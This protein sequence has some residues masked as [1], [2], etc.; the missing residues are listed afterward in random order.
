MSYAVRTDHVVA[1]PLA[2]VRR[3]TPSAQLSRVVPEACGVVWA[4]LKAAGARGAGRHV[5][6][7]RGR[8]DG[9]IDEE[10]GAEV[11]AAFAGHGEVVRSA[12]P[13]GEVAAVTHFGPY[14]RLG[15]AHRA[16]RDW[17]A[18]H[19]RTPAGPNWEVYGHWLP[20]WDADPSRIRTDVYHLLKS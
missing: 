19:G 2:V 3:S 10:I 8:V 5:A 1:T 9:I 4:A 7:Y 14:A 6:V 15:E 12:T 17:C 11:D 13:S 16:I 18:A 20:A